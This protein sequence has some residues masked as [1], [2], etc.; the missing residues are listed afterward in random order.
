[1]A[2]NS[3]DVVAGTNGTALQY[4][5]LRKDL[6]LGVKNIGVDDDGAT[7]TFDMSDL[8]KGNIR[9]V[10][11]EGNRT[12]AV[13][14]VAVGQVFILRLTQ[15]GVGSRAVTWFGT[16]KWPDG[17]TPV[18]TT[19]INKTDAFGFICTSAG[20]YEGYIVGQNL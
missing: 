6:V 11:L 17:V 16:I 3:S 12:L 7:V 19:T 1:M 15:D 14:N 9:Q 8:T 5:N 20:N 4:N 18:L 13:S 2:T 10:V